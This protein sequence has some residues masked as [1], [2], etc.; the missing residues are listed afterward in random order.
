ME[1]SKRK[2]IGYIFLHTVFLQLILLAILGFV[3]FV[4]YFGINKYNSGILILLGVVAFIVMEFSFLCASVFIKSYGVSFFARTR[5][6]FNGQLNADT[7]MTRIDYTLGPKNIFTGK[8][9][10]YVKERKVQSSGCLLLLGL[11]AII[12]ALTGIFKFVLE[13]LRVCLSKKRQAAWEESREYLSQKIEEEGRAKF[14]Q[15]PTVCAILMAILVALCLPITAVTAHH[16]SPQHIEIKFDEKI[17]VTDKYNNSFI[18]CSGSLTN[19][20]N[21]K[22]EH[23]EGVLHFREK[24]GKEIFSVKMSVKPSYTTQGPRND[25][26]EKEDTWNFA[27]ELKISRDDSGAIRLWELELED[28]EIVFEVISIRYQGK[29]NIDYTNELINAILP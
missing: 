7:T 19:K 28:M 3:C 5:G 2:T 16:Y 11:P 18:A 12:I 21:T 22:I 25:I 14:F 8:R 23:V 24:G 27:F 15:L 4:A 20:G 10:I 26:L 13:S 29:G 9:S 1:V 6:S 17:N